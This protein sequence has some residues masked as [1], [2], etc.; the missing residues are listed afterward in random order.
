LTATHIVVGGN[1]RE[2]AL[3]GNSL[4]LFD[5]TLPLRINPD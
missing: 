1:G 2:F 5:V 3:A 4:V